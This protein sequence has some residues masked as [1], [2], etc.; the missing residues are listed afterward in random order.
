MRHPRSSL[1]KARRARG[2]IGETCS[3]RLPVRMSVSPEPSRMKR[4]TCTQTDSNSGAAMIASTSASGGVGDLSAFILT[5]SAFEY[6]A[7]RHCCVIA[8]AAR[9]KKSDI[10]ASRPPAWTRSVSTIAKQK[11]SRRMCQRCVVQRRVSSNPA[12]GEQARA[13]CDAADQYVASFMRAP[14]LG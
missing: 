11:R 9:Q 7:D 2:S 10:G 8:R 6:S 3:A 14:P 5:P 4:A 13:V 12:C 1:P